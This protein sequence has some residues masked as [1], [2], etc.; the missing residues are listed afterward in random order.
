MLRTYIYLPEALNAEIE[1]T[2]R[3]QRKSKAEVIRDALTHGMKVV[4]P[5]RSASAKALV[6]IAKEAKQLNIQG[7]KDLS[8]NHDH[9]TWGGPKRKP[10][11]V[12]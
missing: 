5:K 3:T 8:V 10:H 1:I 12:E 6:D 2:A 4:R 9:Y 11:A 7:P